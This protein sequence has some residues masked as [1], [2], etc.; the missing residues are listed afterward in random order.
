MHFFLL[1]ALLAQAPVATAP[2]APSAPAAEPFTGNV[3]VGAV[4]LTGNSET[5]TFTLGAAL[6]R[7]TPD[8]IYGFKASAAYGRSTDPS[9]G[10]T[11]TSALNGAV[12]LR[13]DRR[14]DPMISIYLQ[15]LADADH[16]KSIEW[17]PAAEAGVSLQLIDRKDGDFQTAALRVDLGFRGGREFRFQYFPKPPGPL[18]LPDVTI[19]APQAG[20]AARY[21][22]TR[23]TILT[24]ELT[25][26]VN[27]P[28][29]PRLLLTNVVKLSTRLYRSLSFGVSYGIAEDSSP[30]EGKANLDTTL[31][32][33]FELSM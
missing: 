28:D 12:A 11:S 7:K 9:T 20:L 21:A 18:D 30:P 23:D 29:G 16:L 17:R 1:A 3:A 26:L 33:A 6:G 32:L 13:G 2:G 5:S 10:L 31:T 14:L 19:A 22:L 24:D 8:W 27:L 25:T 4:L 15:A